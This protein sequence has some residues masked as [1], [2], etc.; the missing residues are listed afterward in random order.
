MFR[1][2]N[3]LKSRKVLGVLAAAVAGL[4]ITA[5]AA[6]GSA[7]GG[8]TDETRPLEIVVTATTP[9][10]ELIYVPVTPCRVVDTRHGG[11]AFA[12]G[13]QRSFYI[14]GTLHFVAQGGKS[15]GCGIPQGANVVSATF[16]AIPSASNY[17]YM[18][19]WPAGT[20][21]PQ[22]TLL[23]YKSDPI[24]I[25]GQIPLR[26]G[27]AT[28]MTMK[29]YGGTT[30]LVI[31]V[32]GYYI[33]QLQAYISPT[34]TVIDQSGRLVS[35]TRSGVGQYDLTWDRDISSCSGQGSSDLTGHIISV[36]T[37]G[38]NAYIYSV[39]NAGAFEDYYANVLITC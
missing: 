38:S 7:P 22:A 25:G 14:G 29:N 30:N 6:A 20:A 23:N 10:P 32:N 35:A 37:T 18:R 13:A 24:G 12:G 33:Q 26:T 2:P 31:D 27:A 19:A 17:G 16:T 8:P 28:D 34:G 5:G 36:Y 1:L 4:T 9:T 39:N 15:G 11:G 21:E 3:V